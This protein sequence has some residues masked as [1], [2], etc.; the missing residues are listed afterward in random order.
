M[1]AVSHPS[2]IR[3]SFSKAVHRENEEGTWLPSGGLAELCAVTPT[4]IAVYMDTLSVAAHTGSAPDLCK[5]SCKVQRN[6]VGHARLPL[7]R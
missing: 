4:G 5:Y 3:V 1:V 7:W 2:S 6:T